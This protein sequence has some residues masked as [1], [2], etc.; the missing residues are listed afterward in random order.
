[1]VLEFIRRARLAISGGGFGS[2]AEY[3][4]MAQALGAVEALQKPFSSEKLL[5]AVARVLSAG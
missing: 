1:M 2:A 4:E 5:G 3:L